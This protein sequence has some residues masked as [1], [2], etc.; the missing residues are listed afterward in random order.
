[1]ASASQ[2]TLPTLDSLDASVPQSPDVKGIATTWFRAFSNKLE[3]KNGSSVTDV[4]LEQAFWR[5]T[6]ALTWDFRT[7]EGKELIGK[8]LQDLLPRA[9]LSNLQLKDETIT[10]QKPYP[11]LTWIQ[12]MFEF[13][14]AV[15]VCSGIFR[16]VPTATEEWK[17]YTIYTN[18]E[19]LKCFPERTGPNRDFVPNHGMWPEKR[20][21]ETDF[22]DRDPTVGVIGGGHSGLDI[23]A[24]LKLLGVPVLIIEKNAKVG[25]NWRGRYEALCLHDPVCEYY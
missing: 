12:A 21:M 20:K 10:L 5:D 17:G 16:I 18:L 4:L 14:T 1:M 7:F 9:A 8:A 13:K 22:K 19:E 25:D 24:R 23:A 6:L 3:A 2:R 15:G 11:D